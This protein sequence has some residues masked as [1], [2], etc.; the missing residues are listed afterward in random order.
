LHLQTRFVQLETASV[1]HR[2]TEGFR[3]VEDIYNI[4]QISHARRKNNPDIPPPKAKL[5]AT[6]YEKLTT[7]FWVSENYLFH[8]FA[9]YKYFTLCKEYN[10]GMSDEMK[11]MQASA[12]LLAALCIPQLPNQG[13]AGAGASNKQHRIGSTIQ[14]DIMKQKMSRMATLLGFHTRNPTRE[15]LLTE[16]RSKG[17]LDQ[18]PQ[19]LRD[20]YLLLENNP[21]PL[22]MVEQARPLLEQLKKEV[23]ATTT[24]DDENEDVEDTTL[25]RYVK[26]LTRVLLLKLIVNLSSAYH[27]VSMDH[28]KRLTSGLDMSFEQVEK[29]IVLLTQ[30]K[31]LSVRIDHRAGCLR[32]GDAELESEVMRS[33]LTVLSKQ[34]ESVNRILSPSDRSNRL[35]EK[36]KRVFDEVRSNAAAEHSAI[37]DRKNLIEKRKEEAERLAQEKAKEEMRIK[38][39]EDAAR[40]AEEEK[41]IAREQRLREQEKLRKIQQEL[42]NE[43]KKRFLAAMG[44]KAEDISEEQI[45]KID[46]EDLQKEHQ[47]KINKKREEAERRTREVAKKLDYLVRAIR[48]EELPLLQ[49]KYEEKNRKDRER[50]EQETKEKVEQAKKQ[51]ED[52]V[53]VKAMLEEHNV[54]AYFGAFEEQVMAGRKVKHEVLCKEADEQALIDAEKGKLARARKRKEDEAK[55]IADEEARKKREEE[56]RRLEEEKRVREE[57]RREKEAKEEERRL[58]EDRRMEEERRKKE[59][60]QQQRAAP[61]STSRY[62]PPSMRNKDSGGGGGGAG[63]RGGGGSRFGTGDAGGY[64]GGRYEGRSGGDGPGGGLRYVGH[65]F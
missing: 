50:Y 42:E 28:L 13:G 16:I 35:L 40:R 26:P 39:A 4:L 29:S 55:R 17:V 11:Q 14:D 1:L 31:T 2:Y 33:Q 18:V 27:T 59:S 46:T 3:S 63:P 62:V 47:E 32:F 64:G 23:G 38:A 5:M 7:L 25:G 58:A 34:L 8:A 61:P 49:Q 19:Y 56:E 10:R 45:S 21:D 44:K 41:R 43:E 36:R 9:W 54:F 57:L 53:K 22:V 37:I 51:W 48:I 65:G 12:V 20:L 30:T 24:T 15:A 60:E 6:Y 52:D